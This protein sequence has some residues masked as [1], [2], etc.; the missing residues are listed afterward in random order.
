MCYNVRHM[1]A[2]ST[3]AKEYDAYFDTKRAVLRHKPLLRTLIKKHNIA[4]C[5]DC[6][7]GTGWH[8]AMLHD[9]DL[10]CAGS[11]L[12]I[13]MLNVARKNLSGKGILLKHADYR[14]LSRAWEERFD[15]VICVTTSFAHMMT[16]E[17]AIQAL[18]SMHDRLNDGGILVISNGIAD[19][20]YKTK[21]RF[22][23]GVIQR[24]RAMY[25]FL[26]YPN[27]KQII[28]NVIR[29]K[30][31]RTGFDHALERVEYNAMRKKDFERYFAAV[32]FRKIE[33]FGGH[34]FSPFSKKNSG[35][36]VV[37]AQK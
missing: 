36:I 12:S 1:D 14:H 13:P 25:F 21:P 6:A 19:I 24:N 31:T 18:R 37:V 16:D 30:K 23:P 27:P 11:D 3:M 28:F 10:Q 8:L 35:R 2:Y 29:I 15:M 5:L 32:P 7:C 33:Y 34:D 4:S 9:M 17:D 26:E 20:T 22:I